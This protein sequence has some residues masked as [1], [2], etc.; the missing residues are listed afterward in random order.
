MNKYFF[1]IQGMQGY[2]MVFPYS[3]TK[4]EIFNDVLHIECENGEKYELEIS[5]IKK[6]IE[7]YY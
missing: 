6:F 1:E 2:L 4:L 5:G 7:D 3:V